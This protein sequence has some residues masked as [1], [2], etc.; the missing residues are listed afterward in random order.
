MKHETTHD[1]RKPSMTEGI[2][3]LEAEHARLDAPFAAKVIYVYSSPDSG[4]EGLLKIGDA[5][6]KGE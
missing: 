1:R 2:A 6:V 4:H 5:T 3:R